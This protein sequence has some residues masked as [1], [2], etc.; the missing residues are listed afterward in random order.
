VAG[1]AT[2]LAAIVAV[3]AGSALD[4]SAPWPPDFETVRGGWHSSD[5]RLLDR[6]GAVL[7][8]RR[9][10]ETV[11][12]LAWTPLT[13][14]SPALVDA[15]LLSEDRHFREHG[16]VDVRALAAAARDSWLYGRRRGASTITMQLAA[17]LRPELAGA[18]GGRSLRQKLR[19]LAAARALEARWSKDEI[20]EAYLNLASFRGELE[21]VAAA[22]RILLGKAPHGV[23]AAEAFLLAALLRAPNADPGRVAERAGQLAARAN[24]RDGGG[25]V[26]PA[27]AELRARQALGARAAPSP[28]V[29]L[30]PHLAA[31]LLPAAAGQDVRTTLDASLQGIAI[32][33]LRDQLLG[34]SGRNVRDGAALVVENATGDVLAWVG[35]SGDLSSAPEVDGVRARRQAG[36]TLKPFL[37]ALAFEERLLTPSS[38]IDDSPLDV[39]TPTG[40]YRPENYDRTFR[41]AVTARVALA[42]SLNVPAVRTA[43][44]V[45]IDRFVERLATLGFAEL[46][47]PDY[48]GESVALG[49][50]DVTL[51]ELVNAYRTLA[52]GGLASPLRVVPDDPTAADARALVPGADARIF[53]PA[54]SFLVARILSDRSSRGAT[55]GLESPLATPVWTAV[56]TGTSKD[57]RDNWCIGFSSEYTIGVWVG[58]FSGEPMWQ[59]SGVD[60]AAPAW[61]TIVQ[62]LHQARPSVPPVTPE[63]VSL[64]DGEWYVAGTEPVG[65]ALPPPVRA[66]RI[67][68][69]SEGTIVALDPDIPKT[70]QRV[71]LESEPPD[72]AFA[73][74]LDGAPVGSAGALALWEPVRGRHRLELVDAAGAAVDAI[75]FEVR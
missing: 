22:S 24:A 14:V 37:Y 7:Q 28:P 2:A 40:V 46:R 49:S 21:G 51:L 23:D 5:A 43:Q 71:F 75:R 42:S 58:N 27:H 72:A 26:A 36:S 3:L 53:T 57:M 6:R 15:V 59:V 1:L 41:G 39:A 13:Q 69:P 73:W 10:D 33:A 65:A 18:R 4:T 38:H 48:Y 35:S 52:R 64:R 56:K 67:R 31:R 20:L 30:A 25:V 45:G 12:R 29:A 11:R 68:A 47:R 19:Q 17:L 34:L 74:R 70:R 63:G 54:A 61:L 32:E 44:L 62:A 66:R 9:V 8:E 60:G 50:A 16:G 55:F